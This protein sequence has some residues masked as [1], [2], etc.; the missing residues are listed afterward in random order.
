MTEENNQSFI[1]TR[2]S[3]DNFGDLARLHAA[4]YKHGRSVD[5]FT[6]KYNTAYTGVEYVGFIA[7]N[8][9]KLPVAYYGVVPCFIENGEEKVLSAQ[10][11]DTMTDPHHRFK[12]MFVEL[13]KKTFELCRELGIGLV[14]G[15][16]NQN[17]YHGAVTKLGWQMTETLDC[18]TIPVASLPVAEITAKLRIFRRLYKNYANRVTMKKRLPQKATASSILADGYAAVSRTAGWQESKTYNDTMVIGIGDAKV[19]IN[20]ERSLLIGDMEGVD[21]ANF[22]T[23]MDTLKKLSRKLGIRNIQFHV[24]PGTTLHRLF[25]GV[26]KP[27]PSFPSLFQDFGSAIR[28]EKV[29]FTLADMDIF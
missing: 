20:P 7:Y 26:C 11:A 15:F 22:I 1:V 18:F 24:S 27:K 10:S 3:K 2:L 29:K 6:R 28:P 8:Q 25:S 23:V 19:W 5:Y 16:P 14:F 4:V 9:E 17:S 12:G 21:D 13:S